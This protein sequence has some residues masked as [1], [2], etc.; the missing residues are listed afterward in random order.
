[1]EKRLTGNK[2][3][4]LI[5]MV[6]A[7]LI[8]GIIGMAAIASYNVVTDA[9]VSGASKVVVNT[10]KQ[11]RAKA[12][13]LQNETNGSNGLSNVCAVLYE[14]DDGTYYGDVYQVAVTK[15]EK[16]DAYG[17]PILDVHGNKTYDESKTYVLLTT[18]KIGNSR[19]SI[20]IFYHG[21]YTSSTDTYTKKV[22]VG[23]KSE[24]KAVAVFFKKSSGGVA[25]YHYFKE[26]DSAGISVTDSKIT[27]DAST[28]EPD[29]ITIDGIGD[30][31]TVIVVP[32]TGRSY[33]DE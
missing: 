31:Q 3:F 12:I 2:G 11:A 33:L 9:R 20:D 16:T 28:T 24:G 32:A 1:M 21:D 13:G 18:D 6:V 22:T 8:V 15:T 26:T 5:E 7:V 23:K 10:L 27:G 19:V 17:N 25:G 14:G 29:S 4:S 30:K